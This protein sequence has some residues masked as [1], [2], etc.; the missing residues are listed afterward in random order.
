[1]NL[2]LNLLFDFIVVAIW[3]LLCIMVLSKENGGYDYAPLFYPK[4]L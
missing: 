2:L 4:V 1:M 3:F